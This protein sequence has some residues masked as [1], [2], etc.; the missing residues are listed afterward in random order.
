M[1]LLARTACTNCSVSEWRMQFCLFFLSL[2]TSA[3][4]KPVNISSI[5]ADSNCGKQSNHPVF[6]ECTDWKPR[7]ALYRWKFAC[8]AS[9]CHIRAL[10]GESLWM[11]DLTRIG[12]WSKWANAVWF[13]L[14]SIFFFRRFEFEVAS[15]SVVFSSFPWPAWFSLVWISCVGV[16]LAICYSFEF[17][18][19]YTIYNRLSIYCTAEIESKRMEILWCNKNKLERGER[20]RER[21]RERKR[22]RAQ[23]GQGYKAGK[24]RKN[25]KENL[26][27]P[28]ITLLDLMLTHR[29]TDKQ[30]CF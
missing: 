13:W 30:S 7:A 6:V 17:C 26:R 20:E 2:G 28:D 21:E 22:E 9:Q 18:I 19:G 5:G 10:Y 4:P 23:G 11:G 8:Q 12:L 1:S 29:H 15:F 24:R 27:T 14:I 16:F 25:E 3:A